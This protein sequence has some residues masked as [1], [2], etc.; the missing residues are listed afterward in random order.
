M[1]PQRAEVQTHVAEDAKAALESVSRV[2][3]G[4]QR[5]HVPVALIAQGRLERISTADHLPTILLG[6][7][8][9]FQLGVQLNEGRANP[10]FE[11]F[12]SAAHS[13]PGNTA[14]ASISTRASFSISAT[15]CT[16]DIVGKCLPITSR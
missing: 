2:A 8:Q 16:T 5:D 6:K 4:Q 15:T 1:T 12:R 11:F 13:Y 7:I 14:V 9:I 3:L 10:M